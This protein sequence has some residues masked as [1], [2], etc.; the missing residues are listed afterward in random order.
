MSSGRLCSLISILNVFYQRRS[1]YSA[2]WK[3]DPVVFFFVLS[4]IETSGTLMYA[5]WHDTLPRSG[6]VR[7]KS[8]RG[9]LS[10]IPTFY[11]ST[12]TG[13]IHS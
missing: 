1:T 8:D 11:Y 4:L 12:I 9:K 5:W 2:P 6:L 13:N 7:T 3:D 10:I